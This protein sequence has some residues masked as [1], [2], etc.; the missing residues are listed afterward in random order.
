[1][2]IDTQG[3]VIRVSQSL[4]PFSKDNIDGLSGNC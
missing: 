1:M 2:F 3:T 4:N